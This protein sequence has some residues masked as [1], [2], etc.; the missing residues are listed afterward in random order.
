MNAVGGRSLRATET[1]GGTTE[2]I[3]GTIGGIRGSIGGIHA[4]DA[5]FTLVQLWDHSLGL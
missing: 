2:T 1:I 3:G 5:R 4:I